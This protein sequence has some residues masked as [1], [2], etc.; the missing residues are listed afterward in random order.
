MKSIVYVFLLSSSLL[1]GNDSFIDTDTNLEWYEANEEMNQ[2]SAVNYCEELKFNNKNDW[3]LPKIKELIS[4][5]DFSKKPNFTKT[6]IVKKGIL[7]GY[8]VPIN[9]ITKEQK[10]AKVIQNGRIKSQ[11]KLKKRELSPYTVLEGY[12]SS[13]FYEYGLYANGDTLFWATSKH[14]F[15]IKTIVP[16]A[17]QFV[18]CTRRVK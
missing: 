6:K 12:W 10:G 4:I 7:K 13:S 17:K 1:I 14:D 16:E 18:L 8:E 3:N 15:E 5:Y 9:D 2:S 11:F